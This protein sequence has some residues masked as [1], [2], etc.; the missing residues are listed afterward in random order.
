MAPRTIHKKEK[1][2][3]D[4]AY[5]SGEDGHAVSAETRS[6]PEQCNDCKS[7]E[8]D[9]DPGCYYHG[10][11]MVLSGYAAMRRVG[12]A[13]TVEY[14]VIWQIRLSHGFTDGRE[15]WPFDTEGRYC[16]AN[17]GS[18]AV[19][20]YGGSLTSLNASKVRDAGD[21]RSA[22]VIRCDRASRHL[23]QRR[24][25]S[26]YASEMLVDNSCSNVLSH[27]HRPGCSECHNLRSD[28]DLRRV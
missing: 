27:L 9:H 8:T 16:S 14:Q 15:V 3:Y 17:T 1:E 25:V 7:H 2:T 10:R 19:D 13:V 28:A 6:C 22:R 11:P 18:V 24:H 23:M 26:R 12:T 20:K 5:T 21:G 4:R